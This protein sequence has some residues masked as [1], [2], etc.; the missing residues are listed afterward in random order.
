MGSLR[1]GGVVASVVLTAALLGACADKSSGLDT[2]TFTEQQKAGLRLAQN[3]GCAACHGTNFDGG[4][5]PTFVGLAGSQVE[6]DDGT[7]VTADDAYLTEA[8][9]DPAAK[10]VKGYS[11]LMPANSLSDADV[12]SLVEFI[13]AL[14]K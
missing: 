7:T 3:S 2:S 1:S 4:I 11:V 5:G 13:K 10:K 9:K 12:A 8:I 14:G 6:L